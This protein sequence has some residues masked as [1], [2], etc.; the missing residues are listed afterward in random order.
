MPNTNCSYKDFSD[1]STS[2]IYRFKESHSVSRKPKLSFTQERK[3]LLDDAGLYAQGYE[4]AAEKGTF[5]GIGNLGDNW[6]PTITDLFDLYKNRLKNFKGA[7]K[8]N[9]ASQMIKDLKPIQE[10]FLRH[11]D[12]NPRLKKDMN[13]LNYMMDWRTGLSEAYSMSRIPYEKLKT[14]TQKRQRLLSEINLYAVGY[15]NAA[16]KGVFYTFGNLGD[17]WIPEIEKFINLH[18]SRI[19]K[20]KGARKQKLAGQMFK[21]LKPMIGR[22]KRYIKGNPEG[23]KDTHALKVIAGWD[24]LLSANVA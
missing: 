5:Y 16:K 4:D 12:K 3:K 1:K 10:R 21:D 7:R 17:N 19:Q 6:M 23:K 13:V 9:M 20:L 15:E 24:K 14:F 22:V 8:R 2:R 11:Y 18:Q